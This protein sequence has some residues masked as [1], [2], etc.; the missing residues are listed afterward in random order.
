MGMNST[1]VA[2]T[3]ANAWSVGDF[4]C[5]S[6]GNMLTIVAQAGACKGRKAKMTFNVNNGGQQN[7][8]HTDPTRV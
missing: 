7:A 8:D 3:F 1:A 5:F 6:N 2:N 4:T